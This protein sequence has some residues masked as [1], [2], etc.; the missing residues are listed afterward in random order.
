MASVAILEY[1]TFELGTLLFVTRAGWDQPQVFTLSGPDGKPLDR[2]DLELCAI[3][4]MIDFHGL[5]QAWAVS[6]QAAR[7]RAA[8]TLPPAVN[9]VKRSQPILSANIARPR[10]MYSMEYWERMSE[11]LLP[12]Q[13]RAYLKGCDVLCII[14]H[15]PLHMLP[16][17]ALR[18]DGGSFLS[19]VFGICHTPSVSVL[20]YC[21]TQNRIRCNTSEQPASML[22]AAVAAVEDQDR[23]DFELEAERLMTTF[24]E[25]SAAKATLL[26]GAR[27]SEG[28]PA[29]KREVLGAIETHDIVHFACHGVF[30]LDVPGGRALDSGFVLSDGQTVPRLADV[31]LMGA[32]ERSNW[33]LTARDLLGLNM[34]ANLV[35]L[36]ACSSARVELDRG[37]ELFGLLRAFFYAGVPSIVASLWNV[38]KQSSLMLLDTLYREWLRK[39]SLV[40]KWKAMQAAQLA[41]LRNGYPHPFHWA[42][43][44]LVGDWL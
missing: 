26:R 2:S 17:A 39:D 4:L 31:R 12:Q 29:S 38:N 36:R 28:R 15:G 32:S 18:W 25:N 11:L 30:G 6:P 1:F 22:I 14:P 42:A 9:P 20:R 5:P 8:L 3:R 19:E 24:E 27:A 33:F 7:Y 41:V 35:T 21:R 43:F 34:Q 37:G 23:V 10:F 40:P 16:F 13:A 44:V